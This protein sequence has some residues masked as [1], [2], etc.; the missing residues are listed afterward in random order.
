MYLDN[1]PMPAT[2]SEIQR[3]QHTR[4]RR[5]MLYGQHEQDVQNRIAEELGDVRSDAWGRPDMS[6]NPFLKVWTDLAVL[7]NQTPVVNPPPGA[8]LA[9][10]AMADA[11][12]WARMKRVQRDTLGLREMFVRLEVLEG[13]ALDMRPVP[14]DLVEVVKVDRLGRI[15]VLKEYIPDP[16]SPGRWVVRWYNIDGGVGRYVATEATGKTD[17]SD[18]ILGD[19]TEGSG[20]FIGADYPWLVD[21]EPVMPFVLYHAEETGYLFDPY[22]HREMVE[23]ALTLGVHYT[24]YGH[25]LRNAAWSQRYVVGAV[26]AG[27]TLVDGGNRANVTSDPS[28]LLVLEATDDGTGQVMVGQFKSPVDPEKVL[29]SIRA[30]ERGLV[31]QA[32][33][34]AK[35]S[36][37]DPDIRSGYSLAV[38]REEQRAAQAMYAPQFLRGDLAA[39]QMVAG[40]LG[41]PAEGWSIDYPAVMDGAN[42]EPLEDVNE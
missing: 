32:I 9:A 23:G 15:T 20:R 22:Q 14:P 10:A 7:Y 4:L 42:V 28:T 18:R 17:I 30:Y 27:A 19:G 6:R 34:G 2:P 8:E 29:N 16:D 12:Y 39:C 31:E 21:G 1:P 5:R 41:V 3:Q 33:G 35:V 36:R 26:P 11:G 40:L 38:D 24:Y 25:I 13:G 37:R